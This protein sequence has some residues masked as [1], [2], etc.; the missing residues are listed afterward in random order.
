LWDNSTVSS[1]RLREAARTSVGI[2]CGLQEGISADDIRT[3][4]WVKPTLV[5]Q[6]AFVEWTRDGL[7][8]HPR[9]IGVRPDKAA[10]NV[11]RERV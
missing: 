2:I 11:R 10:A 7:L 4:R 6:V 5:V 3:L 1:H 9:F 8:R